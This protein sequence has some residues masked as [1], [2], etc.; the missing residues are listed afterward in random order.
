ME[1][2]VTGSWIELG[3]K[4]ASLFMDNN[5]PYVE[6]LITADCNRSILNTCYNVLVRSKKMI[7]I[8]KLPEKEKLTLWETAKEFAKDRMN[9]EQL[10]ELVKA[11]LTLEYFLNEKEV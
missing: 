3:R 10:I 9:K 2:K 8:D 5:L 7:P 6:C 1:K 4:Q 11:L